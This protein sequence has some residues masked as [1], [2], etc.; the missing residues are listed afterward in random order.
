[1][2]I[3]RV[4]IHV[5][6]GSGGRGCVSF[7][8][9]KYVPNG[10]PDGGDGGK[11]GDIIFVAD[12][13]VNS[14]IDFRYKKS[15]KA[16][17]GEDG[18]G[19]NRTGKSSEDIVI[20]V[21]AG[22]IIREAGSGK[23]MA[24][25]ITPGEPKTLARGGRGGR[26][27]QHFATPSRQAPKYAEP[28]S[29]GREYDLVLELK[30]IADAG[31]IG[32]PNA[33]KSTLLS[34]VTNATPK[35]ADYHFTTLSPNLGVV[36][37]KWGADFVLADIPGLIEGASEGQGLGYQFLRHIERTK[38][39]IHV[40]DASGLEGNPVK[41][42]EAINNELEA[43]DAELLKRPQ[44]IAANKIDLDTAGEYLPAIE[45]YAEEHGLKA[46]PISAA[47][48]RGLD[49]LIRAI[50]ETLRDYPA[51]IVFE[52]DY[53]EYEDIASDSTAFMIKKQD[54]GVFSVSGR[55]VEKMMGYTSLD[56]EKGM[57]FFQRYMREKGII[58]ALEAA[59]IIE[60]D[61]VRVAGLF[62]DYYK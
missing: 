24:D 5:A 8:R 53:D 38:V 40:V 10:G 36:R 62:F 27:N 23:V 13:G 28:G 3:D 16:R 9:A 32:F 18:A 55:G 54:D 41:R 59:G 26:G 22:V 29:P 6:A 56:N 57:A 58:D 7:Y 21:P 46:F 60:G 25:L 43:Y 15:F 35:I 34:M 61:T 20:R 33:G 44:I 14:L 2:F 39:L 30:L 17:P 19:N 1:M 4:K 50:S 42:I 45:L 49:A 37:D 11:G 31:I 48:N 47:G 51:D 52:S 12:S